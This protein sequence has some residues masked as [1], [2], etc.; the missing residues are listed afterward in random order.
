MSTSQTGKSGVSAAPS[1]SGSAPQIGGRQMFINYCSLVYAYL[2][3]IASKSLVLILV[4]RSL[5]PTSFGTLSFAISYVS[6]FL[7]LAD[8]GL[9][10]YTTTEVAR[11][12]N[13]RDKIMRHASR[14]LTTKL[15][16]TACTFAMM[17]GIAFA[18]GYTKT[19]LIVIAFMSI[20]Y[21]LI[22]AVQLVRAFFCGKELMHYEALIASVEGTLLIAV[23]L[24]CYYL[25]VG[26]LTLVA[27]WSGAMAVTF[28][29]TAIVFC[30]KI[31]VPRF[32]WAADSLGM[33]RKS[34]F[35][36]LGP[37]MAVLYMNLDTVF[38]KSMID[39]DHAGYYQA[40]FRLVFTSVFLAANFMRFLYPLVT[41]MFKAGEKQGL[42]DLLGIYHRVA[43][44]G[45]AP[46]LLFFVMFPSETIAFVY[47][48]KYAAAA[49]VLR[50][51]AIG[52]IIAW[53]P[54]SWTVLPGVERPHWA[55]Y[56]NA[57][58]A[59]LNCILNAILIPKYGMLAG[60]WASIATFATVKMLI[61]FAYHKLDLPIANRVLSYLAVAGACL[62]IGLLCKSQLS[63]L[64]V[65]LLSVVYTT[66]YIPIAFLLFR[67]DVATIRHL[68]KRVRTL[69]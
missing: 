5:G 4:A 64:H 15:I 27:A 24:V 6:L 43:F 19:T 61:A 39:D 28:L 51:L 63:N 52:F 48:T 33:I 54:P 65:V 46:V 68:R 10:N 37:H 55:F 8:L 11:N 41:K 45:C 59:G 29:L 30:G 21:L 62:L 47:D 16:A 20:S 53:L 69:T 31:G 60:A 66:L 26:L 7:I 17:V 40:A 35:F 56:V 49:P 57:A 12:A 44:A 3:G 2:A 42:Q 34:F 22:S 23:V 9:R 25:E 67:S 50:L 32:Q 38:I 14:A 1:A 18:A 36:G 13:D 58:G